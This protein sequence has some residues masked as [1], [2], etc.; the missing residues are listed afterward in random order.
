MNKSVAAADALEEDELGGLVEEGEE[1]VFVEQVQSSLTRLPSPKLGEGVG[2]E[3]YFQENGSV[4]AT[5]TSTNHPFAA[6][7]PRDVA[8]PRVGGGGLRLPTTG[9]FPRRARPSDWG[10]A[11][12]S[13]N[14]ANGRRPYALYEL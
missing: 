7:F 2:G 5:A 10:L 1:V 4:G 13:T 8:S 3:G 12:P 6:G 11:V 9:P 14:R